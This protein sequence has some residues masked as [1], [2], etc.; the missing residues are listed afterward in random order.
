MRWRREASR[1]S[2]PARFAVPRSQGRRLAPATPAAPHARRQTCKRIPVSLIDRDHLGL[3]SGAGDHDSSIRKRFQF[4]LGPRHFLAT[5]ISPAIADTCHHAACSAA[6]QRGGSRSVEHARL[7]GWCCQKWKFR[8]LWPLQP[9]QSPFQSV[10]DFF[11]QDRCRSHSFLY[12]IYCPYGLRDYIRLVRTAVE[13][14]NMSCRT[15]R[16]PIV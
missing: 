9:G 10:A 11:C 13:P 6:A 15:K 1:E 12:S 5:A 8:H 16:L 4:V 7:D 2:C 14:N 3:S